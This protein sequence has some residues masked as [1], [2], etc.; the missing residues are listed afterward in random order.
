MK[1]KKGEKIGGRVYISFETTTT[2]TTRK[3]EKQGAM[4]AGA[5]IHPPM[6]KRNF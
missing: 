3:D 2:S 6:M 5:K 1:R 4:V